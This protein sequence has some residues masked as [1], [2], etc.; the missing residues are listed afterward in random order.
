MPKIRET[1]EAYIVEPSFMESLGPALAQVTDAFLKKQIADKKRKEEQEKAEVEIAELEIKL[2]EI[3][4]TD[5]ERATVLQNLPAVRRLLDP[6]RVERLKHEGESLFTKFRKSHKVEHARLGTE[7]PAQRPDYVVSPQLEAERKRLAAQARGEEA[8]A[9]LETA[10]TEAQLA[11]FESG[12]LASL[13][14]MLDLDPGDE[15]QVMAYLNKRREI[16]Q[17][18][19]LEIPGT[20]SYISKKSADLLGDLLKEYPGAD[21]R[22]LQEFARS[23]YDKDKPLSPEAR[24][25]LGTSLATKKLKLD[26]RGVAAREADVVLS[27]QRLQNE[28]NKTKFET[29]QYLINNGMDPAVAPT[30]AASIVKTGAAPEGVNIPPDLLK[31][32][33]SEKL[34][35]ELLDMQIRSPQFEALNVQAQR[36]PE[37]PMKDFLLSEMR[38]EYCKS[39]GEGAAACGPGGKSFWQQ[40]W[41]AFVKYTKHMG[42]TAAKGAAVVGGAAELGAKLVT[43]PTSV[44]GAKGPDVVPSLE[45]TYGAAAAEKVQKFTEGLET[46]FADPNLSPL[47]KEQLSKIAGGLAAA[48]EAKNY[49]EVFRLMATVEQ[50]K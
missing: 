16:E 23:V 9:T 25:R 21:T 36:T 40:E 1:K 27:R 41:E 45:N 18:Y 24:K 17:K 4:K 15:T 12:N 22:D 6:N 28:T 2:A 49:V 20:E 11:G 19:E 37:G 44:I 14:K 47:Q 35:D 26:E 30:V 39:A 33:Q 46:A 42:T 31:K 13:M 38:K 5:P 48:L 50:Q 32:A 29:T 3:A 34:A 10:K 43:G 7:Q 8:K